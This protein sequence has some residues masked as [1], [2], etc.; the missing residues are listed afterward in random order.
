M[1][2]VTAVVLLATGVFS[3]DSP[4]AGSTTTRVSTTSGGSTTTSAGTSTTVG[5]TTTTLPET[6]TTAV[7][8]T[9]TAAGTVLIHDTFE[10]GAAPA[11]RTKPGRLAY[12]ANGR[13]KVTSRVAGL[14]PVTY[15]QVVVSDAEITFSFRP[16]LVNP[17]SRVGAIVLA[18]DPSDGVISSYVAAFVNPSTN[19]VAVQAWS[20]GAFERA[21]TATIP[22]EARFVED[23]FNTLG[24]VVSGGVVTVTINGVAIVE[25]TGTAPAT[26]GSVGWVLD[27]AGPDDAMVVDDF[28]VTV[29]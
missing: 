22:P 9:T 25:W 1:A 13:P 10:P 3:D 21:T 28:T 8:T 24:V 23:G 6:T 12:L 16:L 29:P 20:G 4:V 14:L 11:I 19:K 26:S 7:E 17:G 15:D 5:E 27:A 18:D 2:A